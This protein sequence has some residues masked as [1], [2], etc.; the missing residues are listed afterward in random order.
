MRDAVPADGPLRPADARAVHHHPQRLA[1][2]RPRPTASA[3]EASSDTSVRANC[4][5]DLA[6]DGL[7]AIFGMRS[8]TTTK[9][10]RGGQFAGGWPTEATREAA[11]D[12]AG[13]CRG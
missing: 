11:Q 3:T 1:A 7:A 5:A 10:A 2:G 8:A 12:M 13:A 9:A 4:A 6:G